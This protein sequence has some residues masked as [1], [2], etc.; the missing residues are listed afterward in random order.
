VTV[1]R[2]AYCP[3]C[4]ERIN[5]E[6]HYDGITLALAEKVGDSLGQTVYFKDRAAIVGAITSLAHVLAAGVGMPF[7]GE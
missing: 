3:H 6:D 5:P 1:Q 7:G 4:G 2:N